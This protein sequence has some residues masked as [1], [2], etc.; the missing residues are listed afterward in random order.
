MLKGFIS[1]NGSQMYEFSAIVASIIE[2]ITGAE[3][4]KDG[5]LFV[6]DAGLKRKDCLYIDKVTAKVYKALKDTESS[7]ATVKEEFEEF[8]IP[9]IGAGGGAGTPG[10][11]GPQG[12]VGPAGPKGEAGAVGPMGPQ[13]PAGKNGADGKPFTIAK[14]F[15]SVAEM[16][17]GFATDGI[18]E[19]AFVVIN[20][21][22]VQD[23]DNGKLYTKGKSAYQFLTDLSGA[24]GIQGPKGDRGETGPQG[25]AGAKGEQGLRGE[26]GETGAAGAVGPAGPKGEKGDVGPQG[27]RGERGEQGPAGITGSKGETGAAGAQGPMGP[28]G[29]AG[30]DGAAGAKGDRGETGPQG[31]AGAQG[32][33]GKNGADGKSAYTIAKENK[34]TSAGT[35]AEFAKEFFKVKNIKDQALLAVWFGTTEEF[36][37]VESS[38]AENTLYFVKDAA[39]G[40]VTIKSKKA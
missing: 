24:T 21:G 15:T 25:P 9:T 18:A 7:D 11:V 32:P 4:G 6:Q 30:K 5:V 8:S 1:S 34:V 23:E 14:V 19:G 36:A 13:G 3:F 22:N 38:L 37:T 39:S 2:H 29:P 40:T 28:A 20:T 33:T 26:T 12:P 31:P 35:E 17:K 10:P 16:N 27:P